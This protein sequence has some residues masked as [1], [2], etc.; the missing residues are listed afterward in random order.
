MDITKG[1]ISEEL[2]KLGKTK[3]PANSLHSTASVFFFMIEIS[4]L[5][6]RNIFPTFISL[7][8]SETSGEKI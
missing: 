1:V 5:R 3:G 8:V 7:Y 2:N 4:S 6:E